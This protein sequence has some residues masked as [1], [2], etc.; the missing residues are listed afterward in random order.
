LIYGIR[1]LHFKG[2][3]AIESQGGAGRAVEAAARAVADLE[4]TRLNDGGAGVRVN[5]GE[6][7]RASAVLGQAGGGT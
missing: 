3:G 4:G 7:Q 2:A 6:G 1:F 5:A